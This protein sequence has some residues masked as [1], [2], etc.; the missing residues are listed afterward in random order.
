[1][2][3]APFRLR[4]EAQAFA[5]QRRPVRANER[6]THGYAKALRLRLQTHKEGTRHFERDASSVVSHA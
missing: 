2:T 4:L 3:H 5:R 1:M 6:D